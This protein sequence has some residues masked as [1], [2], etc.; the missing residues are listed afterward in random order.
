[1]I[2]SIAVVFPQPDSP[3]SPKRS[4]ASS[5]KLT[6]APRGLAAARKLEP[7]VQVLECEERRRHSGVELPAQ[8]LTLK[9]RTDRWPTRRRGLSASSSDCPKRGEDDEGH[10]EARRD[11]RPPGVVEDR[12]VVEGV[13]DQPAPGDDARV[14]EPEEADERLREDRVRDEQHRVRD[15]ERRLREDVLEDQAPLPAPSA[16]ARFT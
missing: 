3:T 13:L 1:M 5:S 7:D 11:D 14:A 10:A 4:P 16:R 15:Q 12:V 2:E 8:G 6:L 9:R